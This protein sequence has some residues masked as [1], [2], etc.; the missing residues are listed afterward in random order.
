[1]SFGIIVFIVAITGCIYAF[2]TEIQDLT[3]PYRFVD[4]QNKRIISPSEIK[5]IAEKA[6]PDK[7]IHSVLY[8]DKTRA[9]VVTFYHPEPEY[10]YLVYINQ[11]TGEVL[12]V[13][14]MNDDFFRFILDGHF[15]L[16]LP[17][18]IG[19]T[20]VASA[21]LIFVLM[22]ITGIILWFPK[23]KAAFQQRFK[24]KFNSK[25]RRTNFDLHS[26]LGFYVSWIA[27]IFAITGLVWGFEWFAKTYYY[28]ISGGKQFVPY[29]ET[30]SDTTKSPIQKD[31]PLIDYLWQKAISENPNKQTV[32][33]HYPE[34][35]HSSIAV[36]TNPD[37][38]TYWQIDNH[39]YDQ[40]TLQEIEVTHQYGKFSDTTPLANKLMRMNYDIHT[41]AIFGL[42]GKFIAFFIS[43]IIASLPITGFL[44]WYGRHFKKDKSKNMEESPVPFIKE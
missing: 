38:S 11:Y 23:N 25:W 26:V 37:A 44:L 22:L 3:Q 18:Q 33:V 32:E 28:T 10:Y 8:S 14:N 21:T 42:T 40:Y 24:I 31:T 13:K 41:G 35:K 36:S 7:S 20:V 19:Q 43:I 27:I 4:A 9:A 39:Y 29:Y 16:W 12:K 30:L 5:V 17:H 2:Q 15:Y 6:L 34:T 1:L